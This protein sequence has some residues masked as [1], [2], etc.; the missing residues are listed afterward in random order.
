MPTD[1]KQTLNDTPGHALPVTALP[2]TAPMDLQALI[3]ATPGISILIEL[4]G[5][6]LSANARAVVHFGLP[7][8]QLL[9]SNIYT[10]FPAAVAADRRAIVR[11]AE[12]Q[13]APVFM[14]DERAGIHYRHSLVP[15]ID[16]DGVVRR[17]AVFAEDITERKKAELALRASEQQYRFLAEN[18]SDVVW[19]LNSQLHFVY[20]NDAYMTLSGFSQAEVLGRSVLH[21]FTPEGQDIVMDM[22]A[23]R[24]AAAVSGAKSPSFRFEVPHLHKTGEVFWVEINSTPIYD[25]SGQIICYNGIMR[26]IEDRKRDQARLQE[27]NQRLSAQIAE[28]TELQA[29]LKEQAF[30]DSLTGLH[31]RRYLDETLPRE[32]SRAKREGYPLALIMIDLD[33][34]K[35]VNDTFGHAAGDTVIVG[36]AKLLGKGARDSDII[37]RYGGEEF[38]VVLPMMNLGAAQHRAQAWCDT[39]CNTAQVHGEFRISITLSA[40]VSAFPDHGADADTLLNRA[41]AALY[42]AKDGGRNQI[43]A[44][45]PR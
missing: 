41:D 22:L 31:N 6:I 32:L 35:R 25:K 21:F 24:K 11:Q 9:G 15:V 23:K 39:L 18:T 19:Q 5:I 26:D 1:R 10:L 29:R 34:F 45:E 4:N 20:A 37:C 16:G 43:Q 7:A 30:R 33:H 28:I 40:G 17:C 8:K 38:V 36:L 14:E 2:G 3:D 44:A 42:R 27:V 12:L 13:R